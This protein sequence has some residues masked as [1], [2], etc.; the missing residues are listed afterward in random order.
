[1]RAQARLD[2]RKLVAGVALIAVFVIGVAYVGFFIAHGAF[3][4]AFLL[5]RRLSP[6]GAGG[7]AS[8][9]GRVRLL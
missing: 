8:V 1:M 6:N 3:P 9:V 5:D 4:G 7:V 2:N